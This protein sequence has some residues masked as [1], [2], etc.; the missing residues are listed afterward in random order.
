MILL[1]AFGP[2]AAD[3]VEELSLAVEIIADLLSL[4]VAT[5]TLVTRRDDRSLMGHS[6]S[7][8]QHALPFAQHRRYAS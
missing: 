8:H 1:D 7:F 5:V 2:S 6:V 4:R 3:I